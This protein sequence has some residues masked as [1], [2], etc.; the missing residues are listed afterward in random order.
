MP[1]QTAD[2][3]GHVHVPAF[4]HTK[5]AV[6]LLSLTLEQSDFAAKLLQLVTDGLHPIRARVL[7]YLSRI[8]VDLLGFGASL[9]QRHRARSQ[10][11][12]AYDRADPRPPLRETHGAPPGPTCLKS[13]LIR[14]TR[15]REAVPMAVRIKANA[16]ALAPEAARAHTE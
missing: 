16:I 2:L 15:T 10:T 8:S 6:V 7:K 3:V 4:V 1:T 13:V 5:A 14:C 12:S 9:E 11:T